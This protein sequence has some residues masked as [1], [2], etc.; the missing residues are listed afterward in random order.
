MSMYVC[1]CVYFYLFIYIYIC[2]Y[3]CIYIKCIQKEAM[4]L[5]NDESGRLGMDLYIYIY[6]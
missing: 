1:L 5:D 2:I 4:D 3:I 6:I